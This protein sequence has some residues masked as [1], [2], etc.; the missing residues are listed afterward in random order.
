[1]LAVALWSDAHKTPMLTMPLR[2]A[3]QAAGLPAPMA[4]GSLG[5][6]RLAG[7]PILENSLSQAGFRG[8]N[9]EKMGITFSF[10]SKDNLINFQ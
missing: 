2:R 3:S 6:F 10:N 8:I 1:M 7:T 9:T 4:A 5:P